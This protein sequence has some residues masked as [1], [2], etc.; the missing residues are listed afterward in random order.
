TLMAG[1]RSRREKTSRELLMRLFASQVSPAVAEE[2]WRQRQHLFAGGRPRPH[3]LTATVVFCDIRDFTTLAERMEPQPLMEWLSSYM[4]AMARTVIAHNGI[5]DKFIGD[6][7]MAVFGA[8]IPRLDEAEIDGDAVDAVRCALA[9]DQALR[10]LNRRLA[11]R[12]L[13]EIRM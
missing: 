1:Y 6:A 5:V 13:P 3:R 8:P 12:G 9:M 10:L 7:V 2:L 11:E 4:E